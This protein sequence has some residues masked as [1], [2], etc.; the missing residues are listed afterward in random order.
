MKSAVLSTIARCCCPRPAARRANVNVRDTRFLHQPATS[1]T[2]VAFVYADDL[3]VARLDGSDVRRLTTDDGIESNPAFSPDGTTIAFSGQ[4][5]GNTDVYTVPAAGG[6]PTRLTWHPGPDMVQGFTPDGRK[7]LF[8]SPR[9]VFT[10]R[11]TPAL[12]RGARRRHARPTAHPEC[13]QRR[14]LARCATHRLQ[15]AR[16]ALRAVEAVSRRH[17]VAPVALRFREPGHRE[18]AAAG[19]AC[20]RRGRDVDWRRACT[21]DRIAPASSTCSRSRPGSNAVKQLTTHQDFPILRASA[22][23]GKI[24]Y[25]QAGYL[26]LFDPA[27]SATRRIADWR[28]VRSARDA[29]PLRERRAV[30]Q[31][32]RRVA[33]R[34]ARRVR[35]QGRDRHRAGREGRR[36]E[37]HQLARRAR[38]IAGMVAG[39]HAPGVLLRSSPASISC[40]S[41]LTTARVRSRPCGSAAA[42]STRTSNGRP[43][44]A[45][46]PTPTTRRRSMCSIS[47][48]ARR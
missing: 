4:Y 19:D 45:R 29:G 23:G 14:L 38:A 18:S 47:M 27:T 5:D 1:G 46:W 37:P 33:D 10:Q 9:S 20:Q 30:D 36:A 25:E 44:A 3:W 34:R 8:T 31:E 21:S 41:R 7:V 42:D 11:Y 40:T 24:V 6:V 43:T 13:G 22:G 26:H 2:H 12:H 32:R 48:P 39:R 35:V 15:P 16:A 17:R 28:A